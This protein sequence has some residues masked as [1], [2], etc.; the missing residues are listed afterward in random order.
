MFTLLKSPMRGSLRYVN[1]YYIESNGESLLVDTGFPL[2]ESIDILNNFLKGKSK[3]RKVVVTHYH[4]DHLGLVSLF[5]GSDIYLHEKEIET[6]NYLISDEFENFIR[7][8]FSENGIPSEVESSLMRG[9]E[10]VRQSINGVKLNP[11]EE[12]V[13]VGDLK[14]RVLWTPGH[15][16]GHVCLIIEDKGFCGDH[17]LNKITPNVSLLFPDSNPL[18]DYLMSLDKL[19]KLNLSVIYPAHGDPIIDVKKRVEE[20]KLHHEE[21]LKEIIDSLTSG[22]LTTFEIVKKIKWY[23]KWEEL[24]PVDKQLAVGETLAHLVY[25]EEKGLIKR[26]NN[27]WKLY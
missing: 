2:Q 24:S 26:V 15:T 11:L 1:V 22:S 5:K 16:P 25:L 9:R 23:K 21:R 6:I 17:V 7:R 4:P 27:R 10:L 3:P 8:V 12:T 14:F 13:E 18:R 20:I 19:L